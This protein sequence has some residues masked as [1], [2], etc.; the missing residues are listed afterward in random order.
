MAPTRQTVAAPAPYSPA[1]R[2]RD[3]LAV[4]LPGM[5]AVPVAAP[6]AAP[7]YSVNVQRAT[8]KSRLSELPRDAAYY[9]FERGQGAVAGAAAG[10]RR[11]RGGMQHAC[12]RLSQPSA[13]FLATGINDA[14]KNIKFTP[15][16]SIRVYFPYKG[17]VWSRTF[18]DAH[19]YSLAKILRAVEMTAAA[20][21]I[22]SLHDSVMDV[23]TITPQVVQAELHRL[24]LCELSFKWPNVY[25]RAQH[26]GLHQAHGE[27]GGEGRSPARRA[28]AARPP[29]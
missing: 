11:Q 20:A 10:D 23:A 21:V 17:D 25:V 7:T 6:P 9:P 8:R 12:W 29:R 13:D 1:R 28:V 3:T 2:A 22:N 19:G 14:N 5:L 26:R 24:S 16:R 4:A 27:Q 18:R 15:S